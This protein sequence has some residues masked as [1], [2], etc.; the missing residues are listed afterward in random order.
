MTT[1]SNNIQKKTK[2]QE[3]LDLKD[4]AKAELRSE[5]DEAVDALYADLRK[6]AASHL[7]KIEKI[8]KT[9]ADDFNTKVPKLKLGIPKE[10]GASTGRSRLTPEQKKA[11][12]DEIRSKVLSLLSNGKKMTIG[13]LQKAAG[14]NPV[15]YKEYIAIDLTGFEVKK[16][17]VTK[18]ISVKK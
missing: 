7:L 13:D 12:K 9:L 18:Y 16:E 14:I 10:G 17:G 11:K 8:R 6:A 5:Y 3:Y 1:P 2:L 4:G 15:Q